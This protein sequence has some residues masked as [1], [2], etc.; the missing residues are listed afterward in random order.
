VKVVVEIEGANVGMAVTIN[1]K[2]ELASEPGVVLPSTEVDS[3]LQVGDDLVDHVGLGHDSRQ[4]KGAPSDESGLSPAG[5]VRGWNDL[6]T[7]AD[8]WREY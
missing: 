8:P 6:P 4:R 3:T 2:D 7:P 1:L 5:R